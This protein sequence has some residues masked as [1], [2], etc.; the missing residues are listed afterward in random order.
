[1]YKS[2]H[3]KIFTSDGEY[4]QSYETLI[5]YRPYN[6]NV[7]YLDT[8]YWD[9]SKTT[10]K[11]RNLFLGETKKE[12]E[13]KIENGTYILKDLTLSQTWTWFWVILGNI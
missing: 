12:T 2:N 7:V 3:Y 10:G 8:Y 11:Y 5:A 6:R 1:M 13:R 4:L 9:C